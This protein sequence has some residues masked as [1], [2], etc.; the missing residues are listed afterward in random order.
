MVDQVARGR[1]ELRADSKND[2][3]IPYWYPADNN[4]HLCMEQMSRVYHDAVAEFT[5][6]WSEQ[7]FQVPATTSDHVANKL[8]GYTGGVVG[9]RYSP[10]TR[11]GRVV[12]VFQDAKFPGAALSWYMGGDPR[13]F[14]ELKPPS[15]WRRLL[16][17]STSDPY[18][19]ID[20]DAGALHPHGGRVYQGALEDF[21]LV[22]AMQIVGMKPK[23][24]ADIFVKMQFCNTNLGL[25]TLRLY[26][27]G[28]WH[29]VQIDD[30][31]PFDQDQK[32]MCCA[33]EHFPDMAWSS[34]LEK[35]YAKL[36]GSWEGLGGGGHIEEVLSDLTGGCAS[37]FN[38][39]DV[40]ADRMWMYM[41]ELHPWCVFGC[42][43][44]EAEF[45]RRAVPIDQHWAC[46]IWR[47]EMVEGVPYICV[48]M[49]APPA[50][51]RHMPA[52]QVPSPDGYGIEDGFIWLRMVDFTAFFDTV[53][54][55]RLVNTDLGP[56]PISGVPCS[57]GWVPGYPWF[58]ELWAFQ[59][60]VYS[61][62]APTFLMEIL[63]APNTVC[64]EVSQTDVRY[65]D[66]NDEK[67]LGRGLQAPLLLRFYQCDPHFN[68][69]SGGEIYFVHMSPWGHCRDASCGVKVLRPGKY[70]AQVSLPARYICN[71]M[72][73][74]AYTTKPLAVKALTHHRSC[75]AI[76][77]SFPLHAVP[78]SLAGFGRVDG[79][80]EQF[81]RLFDEAEGRGKPMAHG[82]GGNLSGPG[83]RR[84]HKPNEIERRFHAHSG[85]G[86]DT[87]GLKV[88]GHFGGRNAVATVEAAESQEGCC[89]S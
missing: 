89:I 12:D 73:F 30:A 51:L 45:S 5:G 34:L 82:L 84:M 81:P 43:I 18:P 49:A 76:E 87:N 78:F 53:Y 14:H 9:R 71:R 1:P 59:G 83:S 61:E 40:A 54:E 25:F 3:I 50:T 72:I 36:H 44:N 79:V 52:C 75:V 16:E 33:S 32:P 15:S 35:A 85:N 21:Y 17:F 22:A 38:T 67:D 29:D 64:M 4:W 41:N 80:G 19:V 6:Q 62:T 63:D 65:S 27:H 86:I 68:D 66:R 23:L 37:R 11:T 70:L 60:S 57:P 56:I 88:V 39:C 69:V 10:R 7:Q 31:L 47:L 42:N 46:S 58:E 26:K 8:A 2:G 24:L 13:D 20:I 77:P 74:R 55:C 48:C 28:Q